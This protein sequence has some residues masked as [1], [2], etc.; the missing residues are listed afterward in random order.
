MQEQL[1]HEDDPYFANLA[2]FERCSG[3]GGGGTGGCF[4]DY[5][6]RFQR[7]YHVER[8]FCVSFGPK[9]KLNNKKNHDMVAGGSMRTRHK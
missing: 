8:D 2:T 9:P 3:L 7:S 5:I 1:A 6:M 4:K